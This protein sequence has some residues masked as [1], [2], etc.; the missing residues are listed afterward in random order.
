[1]KIYAT[2]H[3]SLPPPLNIQPSWEI[4]YICHPLKLGTFIEPPKHQTQYMPHYQ[5]KQRLIKLPKTKTELP[6]PNLYSHIL[7]SLKFYTHLYLD[8]P[9]T[10]THKEIF[11]FIKSTQLPDLAKHHHHKKNN[12]HNTSHYQSTPLASRHSKPSFHLSHT[13]HHTHETPY[14][15][16]PLFLLNNNHTKTNLP[17]S[18]NQNTIHNT[19][20]RT[21]KKQKLYTSPPH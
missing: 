21:N 16:S 11:H 12:H 8:K 13:N 6:L 15:P 3:Q 7:F 4:P 18:I 20:F 17:P 1:M 5:Y 9:K 10:T 14:L 19:K 2:S